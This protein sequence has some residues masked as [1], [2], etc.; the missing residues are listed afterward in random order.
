MK[1]LTLGKG[2]IASHLSYEIAD[3]RLFADREHIYNLLTYYKPDVVVNCIGY[4]GEKNIDSCELNK[5]RTLEANLTIPTML[6]TECNKLGVRFIHIGSGCIYYGNSP[7]I[8]FGLTGLK[9]DL[10]WKEND[11]PK[12]LSEASFYSKIKYA[13]DLAIG[14]L[15]NSCI[16]RIRMPL[17]SKKSP[18]NLIDKIIGYENVLEEPNS[19]TFLD[20]LVRCID[21]VVKNDKKGIYHVVNPEPMTHIDLLEEY[22]KYHPEHNYNKIN[23]E[24]L[25]QYISTPRSNCILNTD[26]LKNE[27][28]LMRPTQEALK[29]TMKKYCE[30]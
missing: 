18:R 14:D 29:D 9:E 15:P 3:T 12:K 28:F 17:S 4:C 25:N 16:L 27:G 7:N 8:K 30:K 21:W 11:T 24:E 22:R 6:A 19:V 23:L 5:E 2:N 20:D 1:V 26:K 13:A 10:G